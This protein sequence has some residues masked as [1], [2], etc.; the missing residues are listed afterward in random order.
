VVSLAGGEAADVA[1]FAVRLEGTFPPVFH[2]PDLRG[3][4]LVDLAKALTAVP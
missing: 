2:A 4:D 3:R 1:L